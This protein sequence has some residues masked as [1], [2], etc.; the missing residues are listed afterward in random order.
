[1]FVALHPS[2]I[3]SNVLLLL[4]KGEN[5][6]NKSYILYFEQSRSVQTMCWGYNVIEP[7]VPKQVRQDLSSDSGQKVK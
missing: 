7:R 2:Y 4:F 1:M 6:A 5:I 3:I